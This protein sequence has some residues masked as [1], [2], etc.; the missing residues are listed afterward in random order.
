MSEFEPQDWLTE[1]MRSLGAQQIDPAM[2]SKHLTEMAEAAAAPSLL[3]TTWSRVKL[4]VALGVGILLGATGLTSAGALGPLQPIASTA[5]EAATPLDVPNGKSAEAHAANDARK[6]AK[7][8]GEKSG[9]VERVTE[10]CEQGI[11][12]RNRGQYLKGIREQYGEDSA[13]LAAAKLTRC[14]MPVNSEGTPGTDDEPEAAEVED[15]SGE[16]GKSA[17]AGDNAPESPGKS[18]DAPGQ[19]VKDSQGEDAGKP[20]DVPGEGKGL[21]GTPVG[22]PAETPPADTPVDSSDEDEDSGS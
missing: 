10:G 5:V 9:G 4:G 19:E 14:G 16:H 2:Q 8:N 11:S 1:R 15:E 3:G 17:T 21:E 18:D 13:E 7:A 22:P 12:T 6:E 20:G